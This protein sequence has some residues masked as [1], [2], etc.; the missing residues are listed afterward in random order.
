MLIIN[1]PAFNYLYSEFDRD[2]GHFRRY[3]K[4]SLLRIFVNLKFKIL[5]LVYY[6]VVG[7]FLSL[8]SKILVTNYKRNFAK[9][10]KLWNSLIWLSII[11]DKL[12]QYRFGKSLL[13]EVKKE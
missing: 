11:L 9:K 13:L 12:I 10:I 1:V 4:K 5:K 3:S 7:Y 6:D 2:V 8:M